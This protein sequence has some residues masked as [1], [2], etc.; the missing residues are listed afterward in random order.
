[1]RL[2][3]AVEEQERRARAADAHPQ[4]RLADIGVGELEAGEELAGDA[5]ILCD[6]IDP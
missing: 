3:V 2:R 1:V 6:K 4:R 5:D